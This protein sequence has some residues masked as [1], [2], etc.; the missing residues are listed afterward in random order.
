MET[1]GG[2]MENQRDA[3]V[4]KLDSGLAQLFGSEG[5]MVL[6]AD[7][8]VENAN[9][10]VSNQNSIV[11][12]VSKSAGAT[13]K[14]VEDSFDHAKF[15]VQSDLTRSKQTE[16]KTNENLGDDIEGVADAFGSTAARNEAVITSME[17]EGGEMENQRDAAADAIADAVDAQSKSV[18]AETEAAAAGVQMA[19]QNAINL[20]SQQENDMG[21]A[22]KALYYEAKDLD[23][24]R[25]TFE[26]DTQISL[27]EFKAL[28]NGEEETLESNG[29]YLSAYER[30]TH[31]EGLNLIGEAVNLMLKQGAKTDAIFDDMLNDQKSFAR[32]ATQ[33]MGGGTFQ[34]LSKIMKTD[35]YVQKATSDDEVLVKYLE[36]HE[37]S[38]LP[39]MDRVLDALDDAHVD[40]KL[41]EEDQTRHEELVKQKQAG[42]IAGSVYALE[43]DVANEGGGSPVDEL[44]ATADATATMLSAQ[45]RQGGGRTSGQLNSL[46]SQADREAADNAALVAGKRERGGALF[47]ELHR[48]GEKVN[49]MSGS[50]QKLMDY[51]TKLSTDERKRLASRAERSS[52]ALFFDAKN[53]LLQG[54]ATVTPDGQVESLV[55]TKPTTHL[56]HARRLKALIEENKQLTTKNE[57]LS[58]QHSRLGSAISDVVNLD[59]QLRQASI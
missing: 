5:D 54:Q 40:Q 38:S 42:R 44:S 25:M 43:S 33:V 12:E 29:K 21:L 15:E 7:T 14:N 1:E 59:R 9:S 57:G 13:I 46:Q 34:T 56:E 47:D 55:Q 24:R 52:N 11:A 50:V 39:W 41:E 31:Q 22:E 27:E 51:N 19:A 53:S 58:H 26:N 16:K 49:G 2:E 6:K 45:I 36:N 3:T 10:A 48:V 37:A 32:Q 17:T 8:A 23:K 28:I 20:Q 30:Q 18:H 35:Q 4:D